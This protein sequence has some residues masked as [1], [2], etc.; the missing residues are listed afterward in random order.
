[1]K[2]A[3]ILHRSNAQYGEKTLSHLSVY[4]WYNKFSKGCKEVSNLLCAHVRPTAVCNVIISCVEQMI[5]ENR[6]ITVHGI[7]SNSGICVETIIQEHFLFK[8]V[9]DGW[10]PKKLMF[11]QKAQYVALSVNICTSLNWKKT[12]LE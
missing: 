8:K 5:L 12:F 1:M 7:T 11:D 2:P 4:D 9:C 10:V 6:R 3:E